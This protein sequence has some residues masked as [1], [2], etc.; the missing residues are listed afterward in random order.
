MSS[1]R[2]GKDEGGG[3]R[4]LLEGSRLALDE[5]MGEDRTASVARPR[6]A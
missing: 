6:H 5:R 3:S 1:T 4:L 2:G